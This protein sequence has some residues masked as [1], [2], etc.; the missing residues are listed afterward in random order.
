MGKRIRLGYV[1]S[2]RGGWLG[3]FYYTQ[4]LLIALNTLDDVKKPIIDINCLDEKL[5]DELKESTGYPYLEKTIIRERIWKKLLRFVLRF[6]STKAAC[7]I[8]TFGINQNNDIIFPCNYGPNA[9]KLIC[10][11][12]DFQE[13]YLPEFFSAKSIY[14][15]DR[16]IRDVCL[17]HI[18]IIFSSKDSQKDFKKFFPEYKDVSTYVIHF[19]VNQPDFS[20]IDINAVKQKYGIKGGYL[21]CANQLWQHKNHIFLFKAFKNAKERGLNLQLVCTGKLDDFRAPDYIK[22]VKSYIKNNNLSNDILLLGMIEKKELLCLMKNSYAVVQPS[23]FE[24]WN[25][26]VEDCKYMSKFVFLSDLPVHRE[27][28]NKNVCFFNPKDEEDLTNKLLTIKP[29]E[30]LYDYSKCIKQFGEDFYHVLISR[31]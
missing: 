15:R 2:W 28:I 22:D 8:D 9:K 12:P 23:L 21:F 7:A 18:P 3:G 24:G 20:S 13:K 10:W 4:N 11:R 6:F 25:T 17:R 31:R 14:Y 29:T 19:A 26:S 27:Q 5:Y 16:Q 30:E 1:Y